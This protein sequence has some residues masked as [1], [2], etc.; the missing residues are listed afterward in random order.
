MG[1]AYAIY[2][3]VTEIANMESVACGSA[4]DKE[5]STAEQKAV[6]QTVLTGVLVKL[7]MRY[8]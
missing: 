4:N 5:P 7:F 3:A 6:N 2:S 1:I 8:R